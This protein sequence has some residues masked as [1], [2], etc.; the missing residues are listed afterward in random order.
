M[1]QA[2]Q[3]PGDCELKCGSF[4]V[5]AMLLA[6]SRGGR[7]RAFV[8]EEFWSIRMEIA[9]GLVL[10]WGRRRLF[11]RLAVLALYELCL[12]DCMGDDGK[13]TVTAVTQQSS[14]LWRPLPLNAVELARAASECYGMSATRTF[15]AAEQ[16]YT[17][18]SACK[19][20]M[21]GI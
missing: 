5:A 9:G 13:A 12:E 2:S 6:S 18:M 17:R 15:R 7:V 3:G 20:L 4:G 8:P 16:I 11:D 1:A 19:Q 14:V 10:H 21:V